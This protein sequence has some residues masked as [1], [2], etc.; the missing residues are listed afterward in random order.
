M[1]PFSVQI[2]KAKL[3]ESNDGFFWK[4]FDEGKQE[5]LV[6]LNLCLHLT[7]RV[8]GGLEIWLKHMVILGNRWGRSL[9]EI[10]RGLGF[11]RSIGLGRYLKIFLFF[12]YLGS[13]TIIIYSS[14]QCFQVFFLPKW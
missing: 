1:S 3:R 5:H 9:I 11:E 6:C 10:R 7:G 8:I 4:G 12:A 2:P 13:Q 14:P